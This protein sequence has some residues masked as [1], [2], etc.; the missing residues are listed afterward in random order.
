MNRRRDRMPSIVD[1]DILVHCDHCDSGICVSH[2]M[3]ALRQVEQ[4]VALRERQRIQELVEHRLVE[5]GKY[6]KAGSLGD[7]SD[8]VGALLDEILNPTPAP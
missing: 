7:V 6:L 8:L 4:R 3:S 5:I 1:E 2:K